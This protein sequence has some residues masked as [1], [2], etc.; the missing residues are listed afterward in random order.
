MRNAVQIRTQ[1]AVFIPVVLLFLLIRYSIE[2]RLNLHTIKSFGIFAV[3]VLII[4][5]PW[6]VWN[7]IHPNP[8]AGESNSEVNYLYS[9]YAHA[10]NADQSGE[11]SDT[12]ISHNVIE[13]IL[14]HP[15]PILQSLLSFY[16]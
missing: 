5:L 12:G 16:K 10:A 6:N 3:S 1:S 14:N 7:Q 2:K 11:D 9:L 4:I 8:T 13:L 15:L